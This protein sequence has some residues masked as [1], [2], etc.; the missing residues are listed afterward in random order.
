MLLE[1]RHKMKF[2][3]WF[4]IVVG[5]AMLGQWAVFI[6]TGQVPELRTEPIRIAFHLV[7]EATTALTLLVAGV[8]LLRHRPWAAKLGLFG[9]GMLA[10]TVIVSPGY[11]AQRGE[12]P[13]V[14]MFAVL[15]VLTAIALAQLFRSHLTQ[16]R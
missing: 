6:A 2:S 8:S 1:W 12:W 14:V 10:Y 11:F 15:L 3:A 9:L 5:V 4:S 16:R 13:F 7:G